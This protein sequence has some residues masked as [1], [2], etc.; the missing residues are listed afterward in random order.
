MDVTLLFFLPLIGGFLFVQWFFVTRY[1]AARQETQR[2]YYQGTE[3]DDNAVT[4]SSLGVLA[5]DAMDL[6]EEAE[7][8]DLLG[9]T[10]DDGGGARL[11]QQ[12][13]EG[14]GFGGTLLLGST[15]NASSRRA[16]KRST[17]GPLASA[18]TTTT[19]R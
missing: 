11:P 17:N 10:S 2:L 4:I 7:D 1:R 14:H 16:S 15:S 13:E 5:N 6:R 19:A 12:R 8:I 3:L 18:S 9:S